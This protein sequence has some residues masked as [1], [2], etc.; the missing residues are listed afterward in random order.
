MATTHH[1]D[2]DI[3]IELTLTIKN[4]YIRMTFN[5]EFESVAE[6]GAFSRRLVLVLVLLQIL[7]C[8]FCISS[9]NYN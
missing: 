2:F 3:I 4:S 9:K 8:Q 6:K 1:K 7:K 5:I